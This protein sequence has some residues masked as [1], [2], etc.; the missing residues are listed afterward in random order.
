M[1]TTLLLSSALCLTGFVFSAEPDSEPGDAQLQLRVFGVERSSVKSGDASYSVRGARMDLQRCHWKL[2]VTREAFDWS[3]PRNF[4][5]DTQG[6]DPWGSLTSLDLGFTHHVGISERWSGEVLGR[7]SVNFEEETDQS[8]AFYAGGYGVYQATAR[9]HVLV[10]F[11]ASEHAEVETDFDL[12]PLLGVAWNTGAATGFSGRLGIPVTEAC[13]GLT[14]RSRLVLDLNTLQGGVTRLADDN[15][16]RPGGYL[17][18]VHA[19]LGLRIETRIGNTS[20]ISAGIGHS[21]HREITLYDA[22][23][24]NARSVD[25]E[26]GLGIELSFS[27]SF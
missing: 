15:P 4:G 16:L 20:R 1:K 12:V 26:R 25:V 6:Q 8:H 9:L 27:T 10:G 19:S 17:E 18:R 11:Y 14:D 2:G 7:A 5:M 24:G 13:W 23:G 3:N 21:L 22:D